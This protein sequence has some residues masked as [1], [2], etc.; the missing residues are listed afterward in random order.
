MEVLLKPKATLRISGLT[1]HFYK[2]WTGSEGCSRLRLPE[3]LDN[4]HMKMAR[5]SALHTSPLYPQGTSLVLIPG[6]NQYYWIMQQCYSS[7]TMMI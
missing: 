1:G 2:A 7:T 6:G 3:F 5:F 4:R